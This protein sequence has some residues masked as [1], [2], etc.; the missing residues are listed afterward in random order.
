MQR[1]QSIIVALCLAFPLGVSA[2]SP[3]FGIGF[4]PGNG[5]KIPIQWPA[6]RLRIEPAFRYSVSTY[7]Q[8][9]PIPSAS[10][11]SDRQFELQI[12]Q[13]KPLTGD[14]G[15]SR[16]IKLGR[17]WSRSESATGSYDTRQS[18]K[19]LGI[20]GL[21]YRLNPRAFVVF[22]AGAGLNWTESNSAFAYTS[23]TISTLSSSS[24]SLRLMF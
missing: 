9:T 17:I 8:S 19:L 2:Q 4:G 7:E 5:L 20:I 21:E 10:T 11:T 18:A 23:R 6:Y 13:L 3:Q 22:E 12:L 16:G 14:F 24:M 15:T 1:I